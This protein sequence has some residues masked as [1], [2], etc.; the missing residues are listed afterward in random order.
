LDWPY[1]PAMELSQ[2]HSTNMCQSLCPMPA[3]A[4][5]T[6]SGVAMHPMLKSRVAVGTQVARAS[7]M[8]AM[9]EAGAGTLLLLVAA[10]HRRV[11]TRARH[12]V[13]VAASE[14][15][16]SISRRSIA[17]DDGEILRNLRDTR[18][19]VNREQGAGG[20]CLFLSMAPQLCAA[21]VAELPLRSV[22]WMDLVGSDI[23][24]QWEAISNYDRARLL[25]QVAMLDE[26]AFLAD[27][28]A[29]ATDGQQVPAKM[30]W[31]ALEL[32]KDMA[33]E[34]I[35]RGITEFAHD[36]S[37]SRYES[38]KKLYSR[39]R[40]LA[41]ETPAS[42]VHEY[43]LKH[44][45]QYMQIT[46]REGNWAGSSEI[47]ALANATGRK[48]EA[49]GNNWVSQELVEMDPSGPDGSWEVLPYFTAPFV[50]SES[51]NAVL[52]LPP[53]RVFQKNGGGHYQALL[54]MQPL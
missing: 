47:A 39:I 14:H 24:E 37:G 18:G 1:S 32:F 43:V 8:K 34:F 4:A 15:A 19:L 33:E 48:F 25:R 40:Q 28:G 27:L 3:K 31:R 54:K 50:E 11:A 23:G 21:D 20:N 51:T 52:R 38:R 9:A 2:V 29:L 35:P 36:K 12:H 45:K 49:Y 22:E 17:I 13:A 6:S 41:K 5:D 53:V 46:G 26:S 10:S 42:K 16:G 7:S 30:H 44:G